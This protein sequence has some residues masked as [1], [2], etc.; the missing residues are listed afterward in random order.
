MKTLR[1]GGI[2]P[3]EIPADQIPL[4]LSV[5]HDEDT[6]SQ[7]I[8]SGDC[9]EQGG[10]AL[11]FEQCVI[12]R[13]NL[14]NTRL[15]GL[16][17]FNCCLDHCDLSGAQWEEARLR[18][19]EMRDCRLR[20][21]NLIDSHCEDLY[22]SDCLMDDAFLAGVIFRGARFTHCSL[23]KVNFEGANLSGVVFDHCDLSGAMLSGA[24]LND[25]DL[26]SS[27][28]EGVRVGVAD[29]KGVMMTSAQALQAAALLGIV[30]REEGEE[31]P[32]EAP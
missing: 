13:V 17:I 3:P 12:R 4:E 27:N 32:P 28:I 24:K 26:R 6:F 8:L 25:T 14:L 23:R 15:T 21:A 9:S 18:R 11:R 7:A 2:R 16:R 30:I 31:E 10:R 22:F 29:L 19:T 20:G 1:R 5:L